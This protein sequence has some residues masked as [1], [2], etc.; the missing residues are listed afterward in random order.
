MT[1][2]GVFEDGRI[3]LGDQVALP[4]H[5]RVCPDVMIPPITSHEPGFPGR[6]LCNLQ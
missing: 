5:T 6:A 4:E 1:V 2:E 3:K